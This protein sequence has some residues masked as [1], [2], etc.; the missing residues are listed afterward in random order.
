MKIPLSPAV[1]AALLLAVP[2]AAQASGASYHGRTSQKHAM[3]LHLR[4][5]GKVIRSAKT[6]VDLVCTDGSDL[7][8]GVSI[9]PSDH[10]RVKRGGA[11]RLS[12]KT[13]VDVRPIGVGT[14]RVLFKGRVTGGTV[15]GSLWVQFKLGDKICS[16]GTVTYRLGRG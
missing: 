12:S 16:T 7:K 14:A 13:P 3:A 1:A 4:S 2:T 5:G 8:S 15:R 11:Y 10:V 6:K 9:D